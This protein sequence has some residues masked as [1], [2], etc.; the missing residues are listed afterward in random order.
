MEAASLLAQRIGQL[1]EAG[2]LLWSRY[3]DVGPGR[4]AAG[5][6]EAVQTAAQQLDEALPANDAPHWLAKVTD[7]PSVWLDEL[8]DC[9][10]RLADLARRCA[11]T[12]Q[13]LSFV[14][15]E[16]GL[17]PRR[18]QHEAF[19]GALRE[20]RERAAGLKAGGDPEEDGCQDGS[21]PTCE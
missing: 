21:W 3:Q 14:T 1:A 8:R 9:A 20:L 12:P 10:A 18:D 15:G 6:Y 19:E 17:L 13:G 4:V 16:A 5:Y 2:Q 11:C 7:Q